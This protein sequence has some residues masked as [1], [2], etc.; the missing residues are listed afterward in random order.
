[1]RFRVDNISTERLWA[2]NLKSPRGGVPCRAR[3][4]VVLCELEYI[5]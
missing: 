3:G 4:L 2:I 1:M 5:F